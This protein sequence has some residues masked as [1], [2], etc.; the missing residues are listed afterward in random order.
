MSI[1]CT[2]ERAH[3]RA[4]SLAG[5]LPINY[6]RS[7]IYAWATAAAAA[8]SARISGHFGAVQCAKCAIAVHTASRGAP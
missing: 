7:R 4:R 3:T 6:W 5:A 1:A 2:R 8:A